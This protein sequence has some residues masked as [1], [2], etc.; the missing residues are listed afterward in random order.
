MFRYPLAAAAALMLC[1]PFGPAH[2]ADLKDAYQS[3]ESKITVEKLVGGPSRTIVGEAVRYPGGLPAEVLAA[4]VTL[5]P[6]KKTGWHRHGVPI[7]GYIL[8]GELQVDYGDKGKRT[9][10]AGDGFMEAMNQ[11]HEG[12]NAGDAPVRI[13]VVYMG[14]EGMKNV[15]PD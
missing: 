9:Y 2:A 5:P 13:L 4:V 3:G 6:G 1:A 8:A 11:S 10:K 7:F 12:I 14:A 15:I